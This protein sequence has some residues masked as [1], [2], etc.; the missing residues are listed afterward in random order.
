MSCLCA[1]LTH[2]PMFERV[3]QRLSLSP[4]ET[5]FDLSNF[6]DTVS[7]RSSLAFF[8][9]SFR[10]NIHWKSISLRVGDRALRDN[11]PFG[12]PTVCHEA[13]QVFELAVGVNN[14]LLHLGQGQPGDPERSI[15][16]LFMV[17]MTGEAHAHS[18]D[19]CLYF[20][21]RLY[22]FIFPNTSVC[23]GLSRGLF[24]HHRSGVKS[25]AS[26]TIPKV[27][28]DRKLLWTATAGHTTDHNLGQ[29]AHQNNAHELTGPNS[30]R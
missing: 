12:G 17:R 16:S 25:L 13:W 7:E 24:W 10:R 2:R 23:Q 27:T 9:A 15:S 22:L 29:R 20:R 30:L 11:L 21:T 6:D 5:L 14:V 4:W 28:K 19:I 1:K 8:S 3:L 18:G 26:R